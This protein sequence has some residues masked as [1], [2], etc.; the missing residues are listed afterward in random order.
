MWGSVVVELG[1]GTALPGFTAARLGA[2]TVLLTDRSESTRVLQTCRFA[3][4]E[5]RERLLSMYLPAYAR[6]PGF[7]CAKGESVI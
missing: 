6:L 7:R 3:C 5:E 4:V 1:C 2:A